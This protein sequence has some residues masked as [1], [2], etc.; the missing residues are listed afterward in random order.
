LTAK[1][2]RSPRKK[3]RQENQNLGERKYNPIHFP[4]G[5]FSRLGDLGVLAVNPSPAEMEKIAHSITMK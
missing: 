3:I 4:L 1:T 5:V 2:P